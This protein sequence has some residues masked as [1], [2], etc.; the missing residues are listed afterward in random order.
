MAEQHKVR[1]MLCSKGTVINVTRVDAQG[2]IKGVIWQRPVSLGEGPF[3][4]VFESSPPSSVEEGAIESQIFTLPVGAVCKR[5]GIPFRLLQSAQIECHPD[6]W[7]LIREGF[8]PSIDG[9]ALVCSQSVHGF[10]MPSVA[11]PLLTNAT[12]SSS[13]LE[14]NLDLSKSR[15]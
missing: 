2:R 6:N 15:T 7:E 5:G 1:V 10:D 8:S 12:T 14:S 9:Q 11:Q 4:F 13:S 3:S